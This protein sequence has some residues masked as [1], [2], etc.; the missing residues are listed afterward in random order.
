[1]EKDQNSH[2]KFHNFKERMMA[3]EKIGNDGFVVTGEDDVQSY[4]MMTQ[5]KALELEVRTGLRMSN[6]FNLLKSLKEEYGLKSTKK[7]D[8]VVEMKR[9]FNQRFEKN[10]YQVN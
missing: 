7:K 3:F 10:F 9:I 5:I 6:K 1:M 8:A 2:T 4:R